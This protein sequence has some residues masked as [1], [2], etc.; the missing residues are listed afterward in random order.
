[1]VR[2]ADD[3]ALPQRHRLVGLPPQ[4]GHLQAGRHTGQQLPRT[5]RLHQ[6]I[7]GPGLHPLDPALFPGTGRQHDDRATRQYGGR[8]A[9][10]AAGRTPPAGASSR[11]SGS[12]PGAAPWPPPAPPRRRA[13]PR[14][15]TARPAAEPRTAA[16]RRYRRPP[17]HGGGRRPARKG[18]GGWAAVR[19]TSAVRGG[20]RPA[21]RRGAT[22]TPTLAAP[23]SA[24]EPSRRPP[25]PRPRGHHAPHWEARQ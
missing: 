6:V 22:A 13:R 19:D 24:G 4:P 2:Q 9:T 20:L 17:A 7:V 25:C 23:R 21:P 15:G 11:R 1:M 3:D 5:E 12:G 8:P 10:P 18:G 16:C 14:P